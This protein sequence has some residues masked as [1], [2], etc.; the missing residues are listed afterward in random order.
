MPWNSFW[1]KLK[2]SAINSRFC[3]SN[4]IL[5]RYMKIEYI[6]VMWNSAE[7][8]QILKK[9]SRHGPAGTQTLYSPLKNVG[10]N[11]YSSMKFF[12]RIIQTFFDIENWLWKSDF[13]TFWQLPHC[14]FTK[15]N[16]LAKNIPNFV[17][18]PPW[19]DDNPYYIFF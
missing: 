16:H 14:Q 7:K 10:L 1:W 19:K 17:S 9:L 5:A 15:Y 12:F 2:N 18:P 11:W 13:D 4:I 3:L 6:Y 8:Q